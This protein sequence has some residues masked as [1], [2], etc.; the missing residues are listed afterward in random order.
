LIGWRRASALRAH[1]D[2]GESRP[3]PFGVVL[4]A[5]GGALRLW[6]VYVLSDRFSGLVAIHPGHTLVTTGV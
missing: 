2:A 1:N 4:F 6:L 5:A 3:R